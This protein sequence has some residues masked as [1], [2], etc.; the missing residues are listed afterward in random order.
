[1]DLGTRVAVGVCDAAE[2]VASAELGM[3]R[4]KATYVAGLGLTRGAHSRCL[5]QNHRHLELREG[6]EMLPQRIGPW[7]RNESKQS[8][9]V[10]TTRRSHVVFEHGDIEDRCVMHAHR[11]TLASRCAPD[12]NSTVLATR[13]EVRVVARKVQSRNALLV[14]S[15][16]SAICDTVA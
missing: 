15:E 12:S 13:H 5:I 1:M 7:W 2:C 8:E 6:T 14:P 10:V 11:T 3:K 16:A 9:G 4:A